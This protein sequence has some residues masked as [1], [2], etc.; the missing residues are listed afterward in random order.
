[1]I[2]AVTLGVM[3]AMVMVGKDSAVV[4]EPTPVGPAVDGFPISY[5]LKWK[6]DG[7]TINDDGSWVVT[8]Q[9]GSIVTVKSGYLV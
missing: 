3:A 2:I 7:L 9:A 1:M 8:S 4:E 5:E 6:T